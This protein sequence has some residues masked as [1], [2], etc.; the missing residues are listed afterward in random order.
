M[1]ISHEGKVCYTL[2]DR[3]NIKHIIHRREHLRNNAEDKKSEE[4]IANN[5]KARKL[6]EWVYQQ[7]CGKAFGDGEQ[8]EP[9]Y[10]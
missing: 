1:G 6:L 2:P 3:H 7:Q 4:K 8:R 9:R 10:A 5:K